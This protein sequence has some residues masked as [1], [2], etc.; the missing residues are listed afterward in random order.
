MT[1]PSPHGL[2][3]HNG[4][5]YPEDEDQ[6]VFKTPSEKNGTPNVSTFRQSSFPPAT[7]RVNGTSGRKSRSPESAG[8][9]WGIP[10]QGYNDA[11]QGWDVA[12]GMS[13]MR[14]AEGDHGDANGNAVLAPAAEIKEG[15]HS[16]Q[17]SAGDSS[18][19]DSPA[20]PTPGNNPKARNGVDKPNDGQFS[21]QNGY[22]YGYDGQ[23]LGIHQANGMNGMNGMMNGHMAGQS[24]Y[25]HPMSPLMGAAGGPGP[26]SPQMMHPSI[27]NDN[28]QVFGAGA[29]GF[30]VNY[31]MQQGMSTLR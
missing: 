29:D 15:P 20:L 28:R 22:Q 30:S 23:D 27:P 6:V 4:P 1:S 17:S 14:I 2:V 18:S 11:D 25:S 3:S 16:R 9:Q 5:S 19:F 7:Q 21:P 26:F 13:N 8:S 10:Q 12:D 31:G 24:M